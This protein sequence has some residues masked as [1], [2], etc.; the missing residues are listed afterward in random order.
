MKTRI[1]KFDVEYAFLNFAHYIRTIDVTQ[2]DICDY[3]SHIA[4]VK[5]DKTIS[6]FVVNVMRTQ[7][8]YIVYYD[9]TNDRVI[10]IARN[11]IA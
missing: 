4:Y 2:N 9:S 8:E 11:S 3:I 5:R 6:I 1:D 7:N 10:Q